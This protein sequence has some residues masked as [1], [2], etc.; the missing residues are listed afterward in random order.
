MDVSPTMLEVCRRRL[1]AA[2]LS[3]RCRLVHADVCELDLP[4]R[5]DRILGVTVLQHVL[6]ERRFR[7]ALRRLGEHLEPGGRLVVLEAAPSAE[8]AR[9]DSAVFRARSLATW[10]DAFGDAGLELE[11][12][13][14]VDPSPW[15]P[16]LLPLLPRLPRPVA[17]LAL[18]GAT[19]LALPVDLLVGPRWVS[20]SWHKVLVARPAE[21]TG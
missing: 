9:C 8:I 11:T 18:A 3:S 21:G 17:R 16:L 15:R 14:G 6:D 19:A 2:G 5:F 1:D 4:E 13:R 12:V 7:D 10:Q 20:A